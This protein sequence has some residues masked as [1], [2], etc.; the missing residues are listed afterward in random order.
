MNRIDTFLDLAVKQ[1]GSDVHLVPGLPPR[2][3][4]AGVLQSVPFRELSNQDI[5]DFLAEMVTPEARQM[6]QERHSADFAY[7]AESAGRFRVIAYQHNGGVGVALRSI[8]TEL[9]SLES[10][11]LPA[12]VQ[13]VLSVGKGLVLVT[14]PTG[15]GK[16]T[17]LAAMVDHINRTQRG[18][19]ITLE[20]PIEFVHEFRNC[21]VTQRQ[22]GIHAPTFAEALRGA[23]REDPD[24]VMVSDLRDLE[25][26][27]LALTAAET[28][29]LVLGT[30]HTK[31]A[32]RTMDRI[33]NVFPPRRQPQVRSM[34]ADSLRLVISQRLVRTVDLSRRVVAAET[35]VNTTAVA[36][37]IRQ[38]NTH[39]LQS[40]LQAGGRHGMQSLDAVLQDLVRREVISGE[41][42]YE[43]AADRA[44][45]ERYANGEDAA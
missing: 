31:G 11:G 13:Q 24:V 27:Q 26:T 39:K 16:S 9:P 19:I 2:L 15:S 34:L 41:E 40:V 32:L 20:D 8:P 1:G 44:Q 17:T 22:V 35:L 45:F 30:L 43:H 3:R 14:G 42:A 12:T 36:A 18:H 4:I 6:L 29:I 5:E 37:M 21:V 7:K 23:L 10:L 38:G 28:G 25:T 33:I